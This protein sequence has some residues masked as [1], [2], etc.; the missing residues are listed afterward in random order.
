MRVACYV[1]RANSYRGM[2]LSFPICEMDT[3]VQP[4]LQAAI[5]SL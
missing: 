3:V 2:S 1:L 4:L 5:Q